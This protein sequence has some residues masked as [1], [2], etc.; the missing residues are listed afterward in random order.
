[1]SNQLENSIIPFPPG[2]FEIIYADPPWKFGSRGARSG[3]FGKLDYSCM[4]TQQV[5]DLP[6]KE[7]TAKN[8]ALFM[9]ITGAHMTTGDHV[10]VMKAWGFKPIRP[11]AVWDKRKESGKKHAVCGPW[12]MNEAEF[13]LMGVKGSM[14][15]KQTCKRNMNTV[16]TS[17]YQKHHSRKPEIFRERIV[18]RFGPLKSIELFARDNVD[19]WSVWGNDPKL[20]IK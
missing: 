14:C 8:A 17:P 13:L 1:M 5:C 2:K 20:I 7:I 16:V 12:G 15:N 11:D 3:K 6:V 10:E 4:T 18:R 19:G 9:W